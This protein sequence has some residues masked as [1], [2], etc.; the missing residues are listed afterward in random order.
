MRHV[1]QRNGAHTDTSG[2]CSHHVITSDWI[3]L[4]SLRSTILSFAF[5]DSQQPRGIVTVDRCENA[6]DS[7]PAERLDSISGQASDSRESQGTISQSRCKLMTD[8]RA[9]ATILRAMPAEL[10]LLW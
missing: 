5:V 8:S 4:R 6:G 9:Y 2:Y 10:S 3:A 7:T 1:E